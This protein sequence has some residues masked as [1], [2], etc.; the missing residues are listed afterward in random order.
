[1]VS[2]KKAA[3]EASEGYLDSAKLPLNTPGLRRWDVYRDP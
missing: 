2:E 3:V 1:M